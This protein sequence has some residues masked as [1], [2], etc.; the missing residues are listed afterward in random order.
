MY[1]TLAY[2]N[3]DSIEND[4]ITKRQAYIIETYCRPQAPLQ[5]LNDILR[6]GDRFEA[7]SR[8][9]TSSKA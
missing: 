9:F 7:R 2:V 4:S 6:Y 8:S 3:I 5:I 1:S